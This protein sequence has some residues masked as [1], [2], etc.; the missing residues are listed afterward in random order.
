MANIRQAREAVIALILE[1]D[2]HTPRAERRAAFDNA[3]HGGQLEMLVQKVARDAYKVTDED[4]AAARASGLSEDQVFE[5][6]VCAAVGEASR[7]Y[8]SGVAALEAATKE[9]A[10]APG[11]SR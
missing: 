8:D 7:Q 11:D 2:G 10:H 4:V 3:V 5:L 1:G 6:V 9:N